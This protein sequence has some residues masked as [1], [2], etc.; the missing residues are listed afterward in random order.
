MAVSQGTEKLF[1]IK[2][3]EFFVISNELNCISICYIM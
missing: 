1:G 3:G 2:S